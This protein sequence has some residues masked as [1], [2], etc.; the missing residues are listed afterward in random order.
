MAKRLSASPPKPR[1][2]FPF[3]GYPTV[4]AAGLYLC[5]SPGCAPRTGVTD[6]GSATGTET[7]TD[8]Q[9]TGAG[10]NPYPPEPPSM[11]LPDASPPPNAT[12][13][14]PAPS[15]PKPSAGIPDAMVLSSP[16]FAPEFFGADAGVPDAEPPLATAP[17][18]SEPEAES[19]VPDPAGDTAAPY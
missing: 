5:L 17:D 12:E 7:T 10:P 14:G 4:A 3:P 1:S 2:R 9:T 13:A 8:V 6:P 18:A 16:G 11:G 19:T 15:P